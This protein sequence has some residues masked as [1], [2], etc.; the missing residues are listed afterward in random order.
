[1]LVKY[2][3]LPVLVPA[4]TAVLRFVV[5]GFAMAAKR[6]HSNALSVDIGYVVTPCWH[7]KCVGVLYPRT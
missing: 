3:R 4:S 7:V 2:G 5:A 1:M 6:P